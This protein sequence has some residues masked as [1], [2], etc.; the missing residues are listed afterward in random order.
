MNVYDAGMCMSKED[1]VTGHWEA[2]LT[3]AAA[4]KRAR[5]AAG[6]DYKSLQDGKM[7]ATVAIVNNINRI[8]NINT[9]VDVISS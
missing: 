4:K 8:L 1:Y 6:T 5:I 7:N 3:A 9:V 2:Y